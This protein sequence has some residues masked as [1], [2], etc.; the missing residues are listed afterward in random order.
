MMR[1]AESHA[2]EDKKRKEEIETR[3]QADQAVYAAERLRQGHRRQAAGRRQAGDRD[4]DRGRCKKAIETN[5]AAAMTRAMDALNAAQ[6]KAAEALYQQASA[7]AGA[8]RAGRQP[9]GGAGRRRDAGAQAGSG[10]VIDAEVVDEE[11]KYEALKA[12]GRGLDGSPM[13]R[14][15][16]SAPEP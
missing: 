5:D 16:A 6:H 7:G 1:E 10:D 13:D 2:D 15:A 4:G 12:Q 3:N 8:R 14:R 9:G 11:K